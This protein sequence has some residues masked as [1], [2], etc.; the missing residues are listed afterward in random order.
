[1]EFL[2]DSRNELFKKPFGCIRAGSTLF[3]TCYVKG[4]GETGVLFLLAKDGYQPSAHEMT[5]KKSKNG[6]T[7]YSLS[8][9][10]FEPGLFF[11][12]FQLTTPEGA[13][14]I[15]R[16]S[17]NRP[18]EE[19]DTTWQITCYE[20]VHP[21]PQNFSGKVMYQIFPDRFN[22]KGHCD[23]SEKLTPYTLHENTEELPFFEPDAAGIVQNNDFFGG[24]FQGIIEKIP[25]LKELGVQVIYLNPIFKAFSNHRYDTADYL[26][27]DPLLGT[28]EDFKKLCDAAHKAGLFVMLDGVFSHTGSDSLYF[29]IHNR[30]GTG[31]YHNPDSPY[32]SWYQFTNDGNNYTAWWG[33]DTL[34]CTNELNPDYGRFIF[35]TVIPYWLR[36]GADGWRLDVADELPDEFLEKLCTAVKNENP[37][38]I[39]L[40]EVWEDASNK[41]SYSQRRKYLWGRSLDSVM[42][43]VWR[44]AIIRFVRR[45]TPAEVFAE[46]ILTLCENYPKD[47]LDATMNLL[48]TH[49]TPRI[50]SV[51]GA[52]RF[53][54]ARHEQAQFRLSEAE[55]DCA[56]NRL[57]SALFLAFCLPGNISVYYGDEIGLQGLFDPFN[58]TYLGDKKGDDDIFH[59]FRRLSFLKSS[60]A[61]LQQGECKPARAENGVFSFCRKTKDETILCI[62]NTGTEPFAMPLCGEILFEEN[63]QTVN[64]ALTLFPYGATAIRLL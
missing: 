44:D 21:I 33:I 54:H 26:Q 39:V 8:L 7:K 41:I 11:Y 64:K 63:T 42:N 51:L 27:T 40:G 34:P 9:P 15:F 35:E 38:A 25:Y 2:F 12:H 37:D 61:A 36:L 3:L 4:A 52:D 56:K 49:D 60:H 13:R 20:R 47:A 50:L 14:H 28:N 10:F 48:S 29:D 24:N 53:P 30:Y 46:S 45:E 18:T 22:K 6:Y 23:A 43:Y 19:G 16:S 58:R 62:T 1:M 59:L 32:R 5:P 31:A 55:Y 17:Q 57:V